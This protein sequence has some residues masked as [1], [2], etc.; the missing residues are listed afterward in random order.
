VDP[1]RVLANARMKE[2]RD[3]FQVQ[4]SVLNCNA[5]MCVLL[6]NLMFVPQTLLFVLLALTLPVESVGKLKCVYTVPRVLQLME[7]VLYLLKGD[8]CYF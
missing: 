7:D 1:E 3:V 6:Q 4:P 2:V 8:K 5:L